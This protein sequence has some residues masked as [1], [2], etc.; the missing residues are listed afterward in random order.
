MAST[1]IL[2]EVP[3]D[4]LVSVPRRLSQSSVDKNQMAQT[5][6]N[7]VT[8]LFG[9]VLRRLIVNP[10]YRPLNPSS[11]VINAAVWRIP[12]Y[13]GVGWGMPGMGEGPL[14]DFCT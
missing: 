8:A 7:S 11:W 6:V 2:V 9:T 4:E 12:V 10:L 14:K 5:H 3:H 13:R 1:S